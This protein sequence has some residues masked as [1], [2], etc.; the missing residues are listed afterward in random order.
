MYKPRSFTSGNAA[1]NTVFVCVTGLPPSVETLGELARRLDLYICA[2]IAEDDRGIH[3]NTQFIVGPNGFVGKQRKV[4]LSG[5]EYFYFRH[6]TDLPVLELPFA[7]VGIII[8][9]DNSFPEMSRCLAV[10]GAELL[11]CPHAGRSGGWRESPSRRLELIKKQKANWARTHCC[12]AEDNGTYVALC[13]TAGRS[14]LGLRGVEANHLGG[15]MV[16]SPDG[17]V[18]AESRSRDVRDEM[19][20]VDLSGQAVSRRRKKPC[21]NLQTR[22]PEVYGVLIESTA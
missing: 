3:Y 2:G 18:V 1:V 12:R 10:M 15:C 6:G 21:F 11:L 22:R 20:M 14:A 19:L 5:D 16:V 7:R 13:N 8:C 9:Y 4:H 17:E